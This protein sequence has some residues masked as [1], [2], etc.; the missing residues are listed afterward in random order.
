M[1]SRM[2]ANFFPAGAKKDSEGFSLVEALISIFILT[3]G[4]LAVL[5]MMIFS[6]GAV[7][8]GQQMLV[9]KQKAREAM[10]NIFSARNTGQITFG[11]I[12]NEAPSGEGIFL[13]GAQPLRTAGAD[14]II[15]TDDDGSVEVMTFPGGTTR[16][17]N[18]FTRQIDI[19]TYNGD[20]N[21][22]NITVTI[23]YATG[24]GRWKS[25]QLTSVVSSYR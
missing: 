11:Q 21:M 13:V 8:D 19:I 17:L 24:R 20:P 23:N 14:G 10:E 18:D 12:Q 2:I 22:R 9:A 5:A 25:Y 3:T 6:V 1:D 4:L 7:N 16:A 15:G